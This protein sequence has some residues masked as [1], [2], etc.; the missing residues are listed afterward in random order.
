V[1]GTESDLASDGAADA[2]G[3]SLHPSGVGP[4]AHF[5]LEAT[6][7]AAFASL[8]R[9]STPRADRYALGRRLRQR[10]PRSSLGRWKPPAGRSDP[11]AVVLDTNE[12][13]VQRLIPVRIGRMSASPFAFLR[14]AAAIMA[15]DFA[16]LP[17]TGIL[18]VI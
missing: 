16:G 18:P 11:V 10:A 8:R 6:D 15:E 9:S 4:P 5:V 12:G 3:L 1:T 14:G 17:A 13:R 7:A 2:S